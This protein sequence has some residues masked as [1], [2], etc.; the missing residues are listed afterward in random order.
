[1]MKQIFKQENEIKNNKPGEIRRTNSMEQRK[2]RQLESWF[3]MKAE[4]CE[5]MLRCNDFL[6]R[7]D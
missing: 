5:P 7:I 6:R 1:M 4:R 2:K 3:R